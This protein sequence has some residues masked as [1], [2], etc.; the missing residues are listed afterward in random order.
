MAQQEQALWDAIDLMLG[1]TSGWTTTSLGKEPV[2]TTIENGIGVNQLKA[3]LVLKYKP[4]DIEDTVYFMKYR[5][6]LV[7]HGAGVFN[8]EYV[9][10][11]SD[12]ALEVASKGELPQ[13]E[14]KA[15]NE[16]L[17]SISPSMWG[18]RPNIPELMRRSKKLL[19]KREGKQP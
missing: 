7:V 15:F 14:Q 12:K 19:S 18:I 17:W 1:R 11:L 5:G 2:E 10:S 16:A 13:E 9:Y 8:P 3:A 4:E 6:Y